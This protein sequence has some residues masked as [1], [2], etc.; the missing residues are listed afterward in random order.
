MFVPAEVRLAK[1]APENCTAVRRTR[2]ASVPAGTC[3]EVV[4]RTGVPCDGVGATTQHPLES[5]RSPG[6]QLRLHAWPH[7]GASHRALA[8]DAASAP[9]TKNKSRSRLRCM[10]VASAG[11]REASTRALRR[12]HPATVCRCRSR[13]RCRSRSRPTHRSGRPVALRAPEGSDR[14][15]LIAARRA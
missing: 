4:G 2:G 1:S 5:R 7:A 13:Y 9:S 14:A 8:A 15:S 12:A 6:P 3:G 10:G 11:K